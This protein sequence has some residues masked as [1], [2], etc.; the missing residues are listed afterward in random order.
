MDESTIIYNE[1]VLNHK[2]LNQIGKEQNLSRKRVIKI[3]RE[4]GLDRPYTK[5]E[6]LARKF[7]QLNNEAYLRRQY[8]KGMSLNDIAQDIGTNV[9]PIKTAFKRFDI[10]P[11]SS[12][13]AKRIKFIINS[14]L[15]DRKWMKQEYIDKQRAVINIAKELKV[16]DNAVKTSLM[17]FNIRRRSLEEQTKAN[18]ANVPQSKRL[19]VLIGRNLR[20]RLSI[21]I[22][23]GQK[24]GSAVKDLGCSIDELRFKFESKFYPDPQSGKSMTW[25]NYGEWHIDHIKPLSKYNLGNPEELKKAVHYS[26]LQPLWAKDNWEKS[27]KITKG[28][29]QITIYRT[30]LYIVAGVCASGKS[31]VCKQLADK[32]AYIPYDECPKEQHFWK[33]TE[34]AKENKDMIYDPLRQSMTFA[35]RYKDTF[36]ITYIVINEDVDTIKRRLIERGGK[37]SKDIDKL[38]QKYD[39]YAK[40]ADFSGTSSEVLQYLQDQI[41]V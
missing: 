7:P 3:L 18:M 36:D 12:S 33:M 40:K 8:A 37:V 9:Q 15:N 23:N 39:N 27:N 20:S 19:S 6:L 30:K 5:S 41:I 38:C 35:R 24:T 14:K 22:T 10:V 11:R 28:K 13:E 29:P 32:L 26:N 25:G 4:K 17:T 1:H 31:W 34:F 16:S 2:N 21:A